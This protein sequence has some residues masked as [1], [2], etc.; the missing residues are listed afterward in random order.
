MP[1]RLGLATT[2]CCALLIHTIDAAKKKE[3]EDTEEVFPTPKAEPFS[4]DSCNMAPLAELAPAFYGECTAE[5][6]KGIAART[7]GAEEEPLPVP[8]APRNSPQAAALETRRPHWLTTLAAAAALVAFAL[9]LWRGICELRHM[10]QA[11]SALAVQCAA[12]QRL[13]RNTEARVVQEAEV[14]AADA[15]G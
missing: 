3:S 11:S 9:Q 2:C 4:L 10:A 6:N 14:P 15:S 12:E 1:W 7:E 13:G 5:F 8:E